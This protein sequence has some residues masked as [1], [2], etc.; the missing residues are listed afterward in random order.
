MI[1]QSDTWP[2][3][4]AQLTALQYRGLIQD[5]SKEYADQWLERQIAHMGRVFD[6]GTDFDRYVAELNFLTK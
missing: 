3:D 1:A 2:E 4:E 6:C 5:E